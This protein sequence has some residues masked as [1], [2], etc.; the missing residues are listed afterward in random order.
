V[1]SAVQHLP[2][3]GLY[4]CDRLLVGRAHSFAADRG[5]AAAVA[6]G[7]RHDDGSYVGAVRWRQATFTVAVTG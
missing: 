7:T 3:G 1:L 6:I 2:A 4:G 5:V